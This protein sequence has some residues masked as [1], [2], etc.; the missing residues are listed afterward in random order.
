M[1]TTQYHHCGHKWDSSSG[2]WGVKKKHKNKE[3]FPL[4]VNL[5][6]TF[7]WVFEFFER[8][9][10]R[11]APT[12][13]GL[14]QTYLWTFSFCTG[15]KQRLRV[16]SFNRRRRDHLSSQLPHST[17]CCSTFYFHLSHFSLTFTPAVS[18]QVG[19]YRPVQRRGSCTRQ[20]GATR[21]MF[22][23]SKNKCEKKNEMF[24][25]LQSHGKPATGQLPLSKQKKDNMFVSHLHT[26][27]SI[28]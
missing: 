12:A 18:R 1:V 23:T 2:L 11:L 21:T 13:A 14:T 22:G 8:D 10:K 3:K 27:F 7:S 25:R 20:L 19:V 5:Y 6:F 17:A 15:G 26:F 28:L 9:R 24:F 4:C 16:S